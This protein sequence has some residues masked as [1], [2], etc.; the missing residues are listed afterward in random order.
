M[1]ECNRWKF[2]SLGAVRSFEEPES[3][4]RRAIKDRLT[5]AMILR[6]VERIGVDLEAVLR[7]GAYTPL[8]CFT[9]MP[10]GGL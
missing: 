3:Y 7:E 6:Y 4:S 5:R 1:R 8:A 2:G 10:R 9:E